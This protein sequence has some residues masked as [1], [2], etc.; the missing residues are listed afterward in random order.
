MQIKL[1]VGSLIYEITII[2]FSKPPILAP[3]S[4]IYEH[5]IFNIVE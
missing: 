4:K 2:N 3:I 5:S 1:H